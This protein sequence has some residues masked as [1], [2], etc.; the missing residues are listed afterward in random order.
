MEL[1]LKKPDDIIRV[2][3]EE[4]ESGK[5]VRRDSEF[6]KQFLM[7]EDALSRFG[8]LKNEVKVYLHL[9]Q[10]G[11]RKAGTIADCLSLHRTETYR[12]LRDLE[13]KGIVFSA[14][15]KPLK[16]MAVPLG[17]AID[18][19]IESQ[20]MKI[21]LLEK[22]RGA[23]VRLWLSMPRPEIED[24]SK[25]IFQVLEGEQ[26]TILKANELLK[27]TKTEIQVFAPADYLVQL[28][29]GDFTDRLRESLNELKVT[30]LVDN[31]SRSKLLMEHMPWI[32]RNCRI[33]ES[34]NIPC[35]IIADE[36]ELL[37]VVQKS[38]G[39]KEKG[40]S[41]TVALWTNYGAF[42]AAL[43]ML[44]SKLRDEGKEIRAISPAG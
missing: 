4:I 12:I 35:F 3:D 42:V 33:V 32:V 29:R 2:Y 27:R 37:I 24:V 13:K 20:R 44:F 21:R 31:S 10:V 9:A 28:Y 22:E 23:L 16:F 17:K 6:E 14:F 26:Q 1:P 25:E 34:G 30:L 15:E 18:L 19:M 36:Q 5:F 38:K 40:R 41:R 8:L 11:G 43:Q 39:D 7:I